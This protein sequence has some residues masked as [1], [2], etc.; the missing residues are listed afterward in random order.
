LSPQTARH[1]NP[2]KIIKGA[3]QVY[4][5]ERFDELYGNIQA[6][7]E[8]KIVELEDATSTPI[9]DDILH[10]LHTPGHASHHGVFYFS[11]AEVAFTGDT[12]GLHYPTLQSHG[13]FIFPSTSPTDFDPAQ[14]IQSVDRIAGLPL[15]TVYPTHYSSVKGPH[16]QEAAR[17]LKHHL[18]VS[19]NLLENI[20]VGLL[21]EE[22]P[23]VQEALERYYQDFLTELG[24]PTKDLRGALEFM[25]LDIE[26]NAQGI[27]VAAARK[28][29][30]SANA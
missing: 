12:F 7:P 29:D 20:L 28:K 27:L 4:G 24:F 2:E 13:L 11:E 22:Q 14:A 16:I 25:N 21:K 30:Q 26:I 23:T 3:T 6:I 19:K 17:Q 18:Q 10:F 15:K 8:N 1:L 9:L 5:K